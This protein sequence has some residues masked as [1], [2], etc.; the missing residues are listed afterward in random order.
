MTAR[1]GARPAADGYQQE[2]RRDGVLNDCTCAFATI[3]PPAQAAAVDVLDADRRLIG[4]VIQHD[5]G[6]E[7]LTSADGSLGIFESV[8]EA[9]TALWRH[10]RASSWV[11]LGEAAARVVDRAEMPS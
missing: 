8:E 10:A 2:A 1:N 4:A 9:A 3:Q 7:A 5:D 6:V 11:T